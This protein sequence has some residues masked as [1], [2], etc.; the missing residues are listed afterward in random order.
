MRK[1][2]LSVKA[3]HDL[4]SIVDFLVELD[5]GLAERFVDELERLYNLI[6]DNPNLGRE[7]SF[8]SKYEYFMF[9]MIK[10][11]YVIFYTLEDKSNPIIRRVV[12]GRRDI[13]ALFDDE[14]L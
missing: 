14:L 1:L 12:H 3:Q 9:P 7:V 4:L 2:Q 5:S 8:I 13:E 6:H 11:S 10:F